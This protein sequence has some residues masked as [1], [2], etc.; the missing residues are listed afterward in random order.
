[1]VD[2]LP[3]C[4]VTCKGQLMC[5]YRIVWLLLITVGRCVSNCLFHIT[6]SAAELSGSHRVRFLA[7]RWAL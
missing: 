5:L 4:D 7:W 2:I 1:L 6:F 3:S